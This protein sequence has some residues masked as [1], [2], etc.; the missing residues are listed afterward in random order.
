MA[1][2]RFKVGIFCGGAAG[3]LGA[4]TVCVINAAARVTIEVTKQ[5]AH[6]VW[7]PGQEATAANGCNKLLV[8]AIVDPPFQE[9]S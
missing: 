1:I 8:A 7:F 2:V 4:W 9:P 6:A 3:T 5:T